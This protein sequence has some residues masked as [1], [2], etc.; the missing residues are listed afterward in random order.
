VTPNDLLSV[1]VLSVR[2]EAEDINSYEL[3]DPDGRELPRFTAGAHIDLHLR[4][5]RIRQYSLCNDPA[6]RHRYVVGVLKDPASRGGSVAIF[7]KVHPGRV[8]AISA[9]RNHFPL[10]S[11]ARRHLLLAGGIG[12]TPMM[13]MLA[14]LERDG[15]DYVLHYCTRAPERT[16]F[17]DGL[18]RHPPG[19]VRYHHDGGDPRQGLDIAALLRE[20]A[21]GTHLYYCGPAGFMA[22]VAAACAHWPSEAVHFEYFTP[23]VPAPPPDLATVGTGP[24]GLRAADA[25]AAADTP[26]GFQIRINS[27]GALYDVPNDKSIVQVLREHDIDVETSCESGLCGTCRTRYVEGEPEHHDYVLDDDER[28]EFVM[29]C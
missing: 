19:R 17:R 20:R 7:E 15:A 4:D 23:P 9:P 1:R 2:Y 24:T 22:A 8:I 16:A 27:S 10:V 25:S 26:V 5:G 12:V 3:V 18:A 11:D 6:E 13:A 28:S 14:Q 29:I 21:D